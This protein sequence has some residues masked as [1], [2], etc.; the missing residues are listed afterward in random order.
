VIKRIHVN[1]HVMRSNRKNNSD[2]PPLRIKTSRANVFA[3]E[4]EIQGPSSLVYSPAKPLSCGARVW[5]ETTAPLLARQAGTPDV[6][7]P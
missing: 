3:H 1:Q 4:I 2:E 6:S 5:I 7:L